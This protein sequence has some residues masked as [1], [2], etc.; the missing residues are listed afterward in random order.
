METRNTSDLRP[1][2]EN[3]KIYNDH[4]D[5]DLVDS[6]L[7]KG[8]I[9]PLLITYDNRI[10]NGHRR[11]DAALKASLRTVPVVV[12]QS[13]DELD[14]LE[15]LI[16]SNRQRQKTNEQIGREYEALKKIYHTRGSRQG[17]RNDL[18][19]DE[20]LEDPV[21]QTRYNE[22]DIAYCKYC[23]NAHPRWEISGDHDWPT[24]ICGHCAHATHDDR[25]DLRAIK[26]TNEQIG[27]EATGLL[28]A[29]KQRTSL[30]QVRKV[31][32]AV[33]VAE[34][35]GVSQRTAVNAATVVKAIDTLR[36][37][38]KSR[39]AEQLRSTLNNNV[40]KAHEMAQRE[41]Y[42]A[43]PAPVATAPM[44]EP[45][46][47]ETK[48]AGYITVEQWETMDA[49][50]R[51][52]ALNSPGRSKFNSQETNNIEWALWSWNPVTGCKHDC[53]YCYARDI[54]E[55]FYEQKFLPAFLPDRL[56][57][58]H[59]TKLPSEAETN[60]GY[61]NVFTCSMADLFGRWVPREW[62]DAVLKSVASAPQWNFLFLTKFPIRMS[63]FDFPDNAW[64]GTTVD[65]QARVK[66]AETAFRKVNAKVKWLSCEPMLEP[67]EFSDLGMFQWIVIG[68]SSKSTQTPEWHPPRSWITR[69]EAKAHEVGCTVY[70]KTN[71]FSNPMRLREYPGQP[72]DSQ[73]VLPEALRYL[74][75][76][77]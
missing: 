63:E 23:Y 18:V 11:H 36:D 13:H 50:Q 7:S 38:G 32:P 35:L 64:V 33:K 57:A 14:I 41:G 75:S 9:N 45:E 39:E 42:I 34:T 66:A 62:I 70:E 37:S 69:V 6:V 59:N 24:W 54:A 26:K 49:E 76:I 58:P 55:R 30:T 46:A 40:R 72:A 22:G 71:L 74:P 77:G 3:V 73:I 12:F 56:S 68:G 4:A 20:K 8:V 29:E 53:P 51:H 5:K 21:R 10:I 28:N 27:R 2:P 44:L 43:T 67:L 31:E 19:S 15:A 16:E 48:K 1:H 47:V 60:I 25:M 17:Q 61:K 65:C 52:I